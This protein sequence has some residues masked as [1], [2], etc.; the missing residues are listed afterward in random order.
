MSPMT[1]PG[2]G[3]APLRRRARTC[4]R[5][6]VRDPC[7]GS[8]KH[9]DR[10][11]APLSPV[12]GWALR[13]VDSSRKEWTVVSAQALQATQVGPRPPHSWTVQRPPGGK[14]VMYSQ[15]PVTLPQVFLNR[16][17]RVPCVSR[18]PPVSLFTG[19]CVPAPPGVFLPVLYC[20]GTYRFPR[21][22]FTGTGTVPCPGSPRCLG[23]SY[24]TG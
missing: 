13:V 10:G 20:T 21:C 7:T 14:Q 6:A 24:C 1:A 2:G 3:A 16:Y 22:L 18:L 5:S 9:T 11:R 19:V 15:V 8:N 12:R 17:A 23:I 4:R